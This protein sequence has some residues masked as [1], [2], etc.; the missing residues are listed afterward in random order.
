M[1]VDSVLMHV[2]DLCRRYEEL[3]SHPLSE[4]VKVSVIMDICPKQLNEHLE[5]VD[6][7]ENYRGFRA[8]I[9]QKTQCHRCQSEEQ[10]VAVDLGAGNQ[11]SQGKWECWDQ[12]NDGGNHDPWSAGIGYSVVNAPRNITFNDDSEQL[13]DRYGTPIHWRQERA[14]TTA[15]IPDTCR[16]SD[17]E[18]ARRLEECCW[19]GFAGE[20]EGNKC[21]GKGQK[22]GEGKEKSGLQSGGFQENCHDCGEWGRRRR[23][24]HIIS[25]YIE[26]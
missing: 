22:G 9:I 26:G 24:K 19:R 23:G 4:D 5:F 20:Q 8:E 6:R 11:Q 7:V 21:C 16:A 15:R 1:H 3:A 12:W 14:F 10:L 2:E 25:R 17:R 13:G 18:G